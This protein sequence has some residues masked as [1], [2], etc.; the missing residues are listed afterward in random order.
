MLDDCTIMIVTI[1][2]YNVVFFV[3]NIALCLML[4]MLHD[5]KAVSIVCLLFYRDQID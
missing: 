1:V 2:S 4:K 5:G 3:L